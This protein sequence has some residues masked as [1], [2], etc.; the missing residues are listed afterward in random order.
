[1]VYALFALCASG[2]FAATRRISGP[3]L[4]QIAD[5]LGFIIYPCAGP[6]SVPPGT[7]GEIIEISRKKLLVKT[8]KIAGVIAEVSRYCGDIAVKLGLC[9]KI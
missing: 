5:F 1:M 3:G 4:G 6:L 7:S 9:V 8:V 2:R